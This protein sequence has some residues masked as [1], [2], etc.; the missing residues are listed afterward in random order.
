MQKGILLVAF[1]SSVPAANVALKN[2]HHEVER[3]F[4]GVMIRWAY[5][6]AFIRKK[7]KRQG[8]EVDSPVIALSKMA[9]EGC[10]HIAIQSLHTIPGLEYE[11]LL[12]TVK[13][14]MDIP[15][16][17]VKVEVGRPLLYSHEDVERAVDAMMAHIPHRGERE[18]LV[19]MGHGTPH[20]SNVFY[21]ALNYYF[22]QKTHTVFVATVE[23]FPTIQDIILKLKQQKIDKVYLMPFMSMAGGHVK[24]D[25]CGE[26]EGSWCT[27]LIS[28]GFKVECIIKGTGE[29]K[30]MVSIWLQ[31][32]KDAFE[33]L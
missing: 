33:R 10:T 21:P 30:E 16:G 18:G 5:T 29:L 31:H 15:K 24:N 32:L 28:A 8:D 27:L 23:G 9:D 6:S 19:L 26:H 25:M 11:Y 12:Q 20:F 13:G 1:G 17:P 3:S 2:I 14:I 22:A 4:P 7:L